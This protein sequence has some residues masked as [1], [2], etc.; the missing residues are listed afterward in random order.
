MMELR[1]KEPPKPAALSRFYLS[2][3]TMETAGLCPFS[4]GMQTKTVLVSCKICFYMTC[5]LEAEPGRLKIIE[6]FNKMN[7]FSFISTIFKIAFNHETLIF[8]CD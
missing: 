1:I 8:F 4:Q 5:R 3:F 6:T 7:Q 2:M